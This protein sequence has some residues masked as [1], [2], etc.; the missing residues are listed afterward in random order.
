MLNKK[1]GFTLVE[2]L[3]VISIIGVLA[4]ILLPNLLGIRERARDSR[5]KGDLHQLKSA[6]R[7][8]YNDFQEYPANNASNQILG[9]G[10][11][12]S[13]VDTACTSDLATSGASGLTYMKELPSNMLYTQ[14]DSGDS[15]NAYVILENA[16]DSEIADTV[17]SCAISTPA[18]GAYYV[19]SF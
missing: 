7:L 17:T 13:P 6:L 14:T 5:V 9:C 18:T 3:V 11:Y 19:C 10:P 1:K 2:L 8:F 4:G 15:F 16:S 12:T